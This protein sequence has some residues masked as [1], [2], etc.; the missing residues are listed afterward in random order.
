MNIRDCYDIFGGDYD[1]V[2]ARMCGEER[3]ARFIPKFVSDPTYEELCNSIAAE[4]WET[5]FRA[6]HTM[7]GVCANFGFTKLQQSSSDL[8]ETLRSGSPNDDT[9]PLFEEV[10]KDYEVV[11][12][13]LA[14]ID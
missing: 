6:S 12:D 13:A 10:K 8:C 9:M 7:K 5:A 11:V 1:G 2:V 3:V 4:D 14:L